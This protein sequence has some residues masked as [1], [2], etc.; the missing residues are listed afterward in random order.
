MS[1]TAKQQLG[2]K[3]EEL[4][5]AFLTKQ[6]HKIISR[7]FR[8][9]KGELDIVS[10]DSQVVVVSEVKS[11]LAPPLGA[12]EF[13]VNKQKQKQIIQTTYAFLAEHPNLQGMDVRFDVLIVDFST[14][15]AQIIRHRAAFWDEEGWG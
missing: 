7:N 11:Y 1:K 14:Y 5:A 12:A 2:R 10:I 4:A 15:P 6:G 8:H 13:R 3:G 9:G